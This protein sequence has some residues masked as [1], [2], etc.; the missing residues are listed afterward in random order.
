MV[1]NEQSVSHYAESLAF[2]SLSF[3]CLII[4]GSIILKQSKIP[5]SSMSYWSSSLS[6]S[7]SHIWS[8]LTIMAIAKIINTSILKII[9]DIL[10]NITYKYKFDYNFHIT[11][12][13]IITLL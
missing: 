12:I 3:S 13:K 4:G 2:I 9:I 11:I 5:L 8:V 10:S 6:N 1:S 7:I